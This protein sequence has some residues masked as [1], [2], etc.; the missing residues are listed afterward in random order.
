[1]VYGDNPHHVP[2]RIMMEVLFLMRCHEADRQMPSIP[3]CSSGTP[4]AGREW[5]LRHN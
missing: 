2:V 4:A 3:D 1:M 5:G